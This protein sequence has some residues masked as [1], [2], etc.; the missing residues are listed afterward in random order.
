MVPLD[1]RET[2]IFECPL[3]RTRWTSRKAG[4]EWTMEKRPDNLEKLDAVSTFD[5]DNLESA[6]VGMGTHNHK[7][8]DRSSVL[9]ARLPRPPPT[10]GSTNRHSRLP[11]PPCGTPGYWHSRS[12]TSP[13]G[14]PHGDPPRGAGRRRALRPVDSPTAAHPASAPGRANCAGRCVAPAPRA[15]VPSQKRDSGRIKTGSYIGFSC[16]P[17]PRLRLPAE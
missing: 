4:P 5:P 3:T 9:T 15:A 6:S 1:F 11:A 10:P 14:G 2:D 12:R 16:L 13:P 8:R 17:Q 7:A